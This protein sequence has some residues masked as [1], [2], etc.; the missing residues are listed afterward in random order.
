MYARLYVS[1]VRSQMQYRLSF[2]LQVVGI[3]GATALDF[4]VIL[5]V[6]SQLT[7]LGTWSLW[8]VGFLYGTSYISFKIADICVG[9]IERLGDWIRMGQFD[10]VL[11]RPLGTLGQALTND[12][13]IRQVGALAQGVVVFGLAL[14]R[15]DVGWTPGRALMLLVM[16][17]SGFVIF[18]AIWIAMNS[19]A[20]WL[21][22]VREATNA[23]TYGGNFVSQFP[24]DIFGAWFRRVFAFLIPIAFV[25]Y[26]PSLYI[27]GKPTGPWPSALRFLS[28][29]VAAASA[30]VAVLVWRAGIRRYTST[31]S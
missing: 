31:G 30:G 8:E 6:F 17:V 9:K 28:P 10:I 12:V 2:A 1:R 19:A 23:F 7:S 11:I 27:L 15:V 5:V 22:N 4:L 3:L 20:F 26:F 21:V 24:L 14:G 29:A 13:D 25:N 16:L 18:C